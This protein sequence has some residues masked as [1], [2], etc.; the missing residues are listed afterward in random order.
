MTTSTILTYDFGT[1]PEEV[2]RE[3]FAWFFDTVIIDR[4][5][6]YAPCPPILNGN[7]THP[8][9]RDDLLTILNDLAYCALNVEKTWRGSRLPN[10]RPDGNG[11]PSAALRISILAALGIK[12]V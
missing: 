7:T 2:I 6:S 10:G 1:T 3:R 8:D 11:H 12:E 5:D 9:A 4:Q